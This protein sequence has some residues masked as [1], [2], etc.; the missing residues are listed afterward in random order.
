MALALIVK[1]GPLPKLLLAIGTAIG[2]AATV[3][4]AVMVIRFFSDLLRGADPDV[5]G[6]VVSAGIHTALMIP[7]S[8]AF[9][10]YLLHVVKNPAFSNERRFVW[11]LATLLGGPLVWPVYFVLH[12]W[13][14]P[15]S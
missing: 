4:G 11:L 9:I 10:V 13:R 1:L 14:E 12:V 3:Y 7:T 8:A 15:K 6:F 2:L 5:E